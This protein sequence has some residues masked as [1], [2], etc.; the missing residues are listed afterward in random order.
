MDNE[1]KEKLDN[2][3]LRFKLN[4]IRYDKV[5]CRKKTI[6]NKTGNGMWIKMLWQISAILAIA[7]GIGLISNALRPDSLQLVGSWSAEAR[8]ATATREHLII[9]LSE[10]AKV[11]TEKTAVFI[12]ARSDEDYRK[13]HIQGAKSLPWQDVD[14]R[15]I[16]IAEDISLDMAIITYCDGETCKLSHDLA[17][18][19]HDMGF[20]KVRVLVNG[21]SL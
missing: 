5:L 6:M 21:W 7:L 1:K 10:A 9:P 4:N 16:K 11:F 18:F 3:M 2:Y 15:F 19:L 17:L 13:G 12:D 8:M 20:K 14:Q